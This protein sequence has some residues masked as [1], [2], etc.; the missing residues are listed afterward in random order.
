[1]E[2]DR[3]QDK[4]EQPLQHKQQDQQLHGQHQTL[5][6]KEEEKVDNADH[7]NAVA[8]AK[9]RNTQNAWV[10]FV[11]NPELQELASEEEFSESSD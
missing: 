4:E 3:K 7:S 8:K 11:L 6:K 10:D 1:M 5:V 2:I 9:E